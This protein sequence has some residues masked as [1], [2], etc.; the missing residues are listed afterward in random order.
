MDESQRSVWQNLSIACE[1]G[2]LQAVR[3]I[4]DGGFQITQRRYDFCLNLVCK[5]CNYGPVPSFQGYVDTARLLMDRGANPNATISK[6]T[7]VGSPLLS[8]S[9]LCHLALARLLLVRGANVNYRN[10]EANGTAL[11]NTCRYK[12]YRSASDSVDF[13]RLLLDR[14]ADIHL[15]DVHGRTPLHFVCGVPSRYDANFV[16]EEVRLVRL[17]LERG[18]ASD[19]YREDDEGKTPLEMH[20][21]YDLLDDLDEEGENLVAVAVQHSF[22][23]AFLRKH[24]AITVRKYVIGPPA[25]H[26]FRR[27]EHHAPHI[28]SFLV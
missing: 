16:G 23:K 26:P 17:L 4:L 28:V 1:N 20:S 27:I 25:E 15:A 18:A 19:F 5:D 9:S 2:D 11:L 8:T 21:D 13:A 14:G 22:M 24:F 12:S 10:S 6:A 7:S 3:Q